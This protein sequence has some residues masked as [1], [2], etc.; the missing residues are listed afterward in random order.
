MFYHS[1]ICGPSYMIENRVNYLTCN[2]NFHRRSFLFSN[3]LCIAKVLIFY[4]HVVESV[5]N[6]F[7]NDDIKYS[8]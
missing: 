8:H 6:V 4:I 7:A 2:A 3:I 1:T 5:R